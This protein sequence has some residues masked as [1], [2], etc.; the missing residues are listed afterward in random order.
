MLKIY[1][2]VNLTHL[3]FLAAIIA[4]LSALVLPPAA[5]GADS[6]TI[7]TTTLGSGQVNVYYYTALEATGGSGP[8]TW[9]VSA[10]NL[11]SGLTLSTAGIISGTP[12]TEGTST[13][14][15]QVTDSASHTAT[16]SYTFTVSPS[17]ASSLTI[18]T[19]TLPDGTADTYY[20]TQLAAAGGSG[21][22][23]WAV[24]SGSL[25]P[26]LTL[27][28]A[29]LIYGIPTTAGTYPF[30]VTVNDH[31]SRTVNKNFSLK[32]NSSAST[33]PLAISTVSLPQGT[34]G[35]SFSAQLAA[36]GGTAPYSWTI[37]SGGLPP[38]LTLTA[39][40]LISGQPS[41]QGTYSFG[42]RVSDNLSQTAGQTYSLVI[43]PGTQPVSITTD[44]LPG[45]TAGTPYSATL[46]A[47][48][49]SE[50]Y[51]FQV[52]GGSLPDGLSLSPS[53]TIAGK[54]VTTDNYTFTITATDSG[55]LIASRTYTIAISAAT[56]PSPTPGSPA[57][58]AASAP[59]A[60]QKETGSGF[61][62]TW[63]IIGVAIIIGAL[64]LTR[65]LILVY[66]SKR[67]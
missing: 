57:P 31:A 67:G 33:I 18:T 24:S 35:N 50:P 59:Q 1:R 53:G 12:V 21:A 65:I 14:T 63:L 47:A 44:S 56:T 43:S 48:G 25:P 23:N 3:I 61:D 60:G 10:G 22:Y 37:S 41:T 11:P 16:R 9:R 26:G 40:G 55:S 39:A 29:G 49:G 20:S 62:F 6:I 4:S 8:Y 7:S 15:V 54:P 5:A 52:T 32:I 36:T 51:T 66:K 64:I 42:V 17:S 38:G 13:F 28:T 27:A 19:T 58:D 2:Q 45:G 34:A 46:S 30:S